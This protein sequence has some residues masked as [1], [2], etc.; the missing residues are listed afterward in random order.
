MASRLAVMDA[1]LSTPGVDLAALGHTGFTLLH[2][3]A[4]DWGPATKTTAALK[5]RV[6]G[7]VARLLAAGVDANKQAGDFQ[8]TA[9]HT[10]AEQWS[11]LGPY[12]MPHT[13]P[14]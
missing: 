2:R 5:A 4:A 10:A 8:R 1:V 9:L 11:M 13:N 14:K 12:L 6:P 3:M 7:L